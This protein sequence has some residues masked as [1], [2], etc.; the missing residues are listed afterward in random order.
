MSQA[1]AWLQSQAQDIKDQAQSTDILVAMFLRA[2]R[3]LAHGIDA[4]APVSSQAFRNDL[5]NL[6]QEL[7]RFTSQSP[8]IPGGLRPDFHESPSIANVVA[9]NPNGLA[10]LAPPAPINV[11][12]TMTSQPTAPLTP[13]APVAPTATY[14]EQKPEFASPIEPISHTPTATQTVSREVKIS[15]QTRVTRPLASSELLDSKS[16]MTVQDV[17]RRLNLSSDSEV[18]RM[19]ISL[20]YE[21]LRTILPPVD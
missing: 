1:Y 11:P 16:L 9:P 15:E 2:K 8:G 19:L 3:G 7:N 10:K 21:K 13:S 5:K 17:K 14:L 18:I 4:D 12:Q 20:G 6:A